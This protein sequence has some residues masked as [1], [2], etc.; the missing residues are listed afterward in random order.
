MSLNFPELQFTQLQNE[1]TNYTLLQ[2]SIFPAP[3]THSGE[4]FSNC[5]S[6]PQ[7]RITGGHL[8]TGQT[9]V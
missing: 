2:D 5:R 1:V 6:D 9:T 4:L 7:G 8:G 3:G